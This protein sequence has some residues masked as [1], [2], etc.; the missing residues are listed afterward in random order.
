MV[1][2]NLKYGVPK[3][4]KAISVISTSSTQIVTEDEN[5]RCVM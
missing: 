4:Q 3:S 2:P 5:A 1:S